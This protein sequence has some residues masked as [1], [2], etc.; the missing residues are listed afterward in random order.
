MHCTQCGKVLQQAAVFCEHCGARQTTLPTTSLANDSHSTVSP[1]RTTPPDTLV[2]QTGQPSLPL[3]TTAVATSKIGRK[4]IFLTLAA[5]G[6]I[7]LG[8]TTSYMAWSSRATTDEASQRLAQV[9]AD[10]ARQVAEAAAS[11]TA[12][13]ARRMAAEEASERVEI[14]A[15]Q[16]ALR[17]KIVEEEALA[18]SSAGPKK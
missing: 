14:A 16:E 15:A 4:S 8:G 11:V 17:M 18:R 3:G 12:A 5:S 1:V 13:D 7:L 10:S 9:S 2:Q 6:L